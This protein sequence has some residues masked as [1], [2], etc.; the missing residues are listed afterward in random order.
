MWNQTD[1]AGNKHILLKKLVEVTFLY[2]ERKYH[3]VNLTN[4]KKS[5]R[6]DKPWGFDMIQNKRILSK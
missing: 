6:N 2:Q 4:T 3:I 1:V 5:I